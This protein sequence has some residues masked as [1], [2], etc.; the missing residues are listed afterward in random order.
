[1]FYINIDDRWISPDWV[2]DD[3][4]SPKFMK[5]LKWAGPDHLTLKSGF[6]GLQS[7]YPQLGQRLIRRGNNRLIHLIDLFTHTLGGKLNGRSAWNGCLTLLYIRIRMSETSGPV[8]VRSLSF[9]GSKVIRR[10]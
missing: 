4:S 1:M 5:P 9:S 3:G 10:H 6:F 7:L 8:A 2:Y